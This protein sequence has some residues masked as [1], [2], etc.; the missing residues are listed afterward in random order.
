MHQQGT[1][2][3]GRTLRRGLQNPHPTPRQ[4]KAIDMAEQYLRHLSATN[5]PKET[6]TQAAARAGML[7]DRL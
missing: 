4:Q 6:I 5:G 1:R 3:S 7:P 2:I